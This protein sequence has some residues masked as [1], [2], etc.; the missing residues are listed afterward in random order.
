MKSY[1][2]IVIVGWALS[3]GGVGAF[4]TEFDSLEDCRAAAATISKDIEKDTFAT[5]VSIGCHEK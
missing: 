2:L 1:V 3:Q 4:S 5:I